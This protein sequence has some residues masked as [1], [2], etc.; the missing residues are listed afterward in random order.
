MNKTN[1][2][3]TT[4]II[5]FLIGIVIVGYKSYEDGLTFE[6][7]KSALGKTFNI[8]QEQDITQKTE[9]TLAEADE[10]YFKAKYDKAIKVYEANLNILSREQKLRLAE[11]YNQNKQYDKSIETYKKLHREDAIYIDDLIEKY[12]VL[13]QKL[14]ESGDGNKASELFKETLELSKNGPLDLKVKEAFIKFALNHNSENDAKLAYSILSEIK[15]KGAKLS[16]T[17]REVNL[18]LGDLAIGLGDT[19]KAN[20]HYADN[21]TANNIDYES[22]TRIGHTYYDN[23]EYDNAITSYKKALSLNGNDWEALVGIGDSYYELGDKKHSISWYKRALAHNQE[24]VYLFFKLGSVQQ[25]LGFKM[26]AIEN[27]H[28]AISISPDGFS[29]KEAQKRLDELNGKLITE[30]D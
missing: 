5:L 2:I 1:V 22:Y 7:V 19:E 28:K 11:S 10:I 9:L 18:I 30:I 26:E 16:I 15:D 17:E 13:T 25:E 29:G 27:Y 14:N 20:Q 12:L 4:L 21:T 24:N 6:D 3:L 23:Q 8:N